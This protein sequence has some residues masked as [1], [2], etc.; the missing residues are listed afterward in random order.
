MRM[1]ES[2][3]DSKPQAAQS[4]LS[5]HARPRRPFGQ[6]DS[7]QKARLRILCLLAFVHFLALVK[8]RRDSAF[9]RLVTRPLDRSRSCSS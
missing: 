4:L 8:I 1:V 3:R 2:K 6:S 7:R 9:E 5:R